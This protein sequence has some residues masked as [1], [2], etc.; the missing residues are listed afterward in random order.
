[1]WGKRKSAAFGM[2]AGAALLGVYFAALTLV[3]GWAFTIEQFGQFWYYIVALAAGFGLQVS[4]CSSGCAS[5]WRARRARP[6]SPP[7]ARP[8]PRR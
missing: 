1:M 3:S 4:A 7:P 5:S 8:R 2:L 6:W